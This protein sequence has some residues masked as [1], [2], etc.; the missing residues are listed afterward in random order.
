MAIGNSGPY[1]MSVDAD[2]N[3]MRDELV[4]HVVRRTQDGYVPITL[5]FVEGDPVT[6][7]ATTEEGGNPFPAFNMPREL[8]ELW[9]A[10]LAGYLLGVE[11]DLVRANQDLKNRLQRSQTQ[12]E[13]L[14]AGIGRLGGVKE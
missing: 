6:F 14:I 10:T 4:I 12:L 5:T 3:F 8:A 1:R 11:G 13:N 7:D 2:F 9:M